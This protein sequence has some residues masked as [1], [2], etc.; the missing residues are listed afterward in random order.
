MQAQPL[1]SDDSPGRRNGNP[2]QDS[3]LDRVAWWAMVHDVAE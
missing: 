1:G 2:L 3:C